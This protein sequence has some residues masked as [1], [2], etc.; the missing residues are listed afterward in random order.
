M[1]ELLCGSKKHP[2]CMT[3]KEVK[4]KIS[5]REVFMHGQDTPSS[6]VNRYCYCGVIGI[7]S[8]GEN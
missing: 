7:Q 1:P 4:S 5:E 6:C 2:Y 3:P 8:R